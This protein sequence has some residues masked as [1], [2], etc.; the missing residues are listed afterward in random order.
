MDANF[1]NKRKNGRKVVWGMQKK[2]TAAQPSPDFFL[3]SAEIMFFV[4]N[5]Y[6]VITDIPWIPHRTT[7][8]YNTLN[9]KKNNF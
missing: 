7:I 9:R 5:I 1:W 3:I 4:Q 6:L 2:V 8:R